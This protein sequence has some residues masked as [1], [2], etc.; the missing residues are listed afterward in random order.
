[1]RVRSGVIKLLI[2]FM[3]VALVVT[4]I[5]LTIWLLIYAAHRSTHVIGRCKQCDYDLRD[6]GDRR[7]CPE[8]G[9]P[10]YVNERGDVVS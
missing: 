6:L 2:A 8:C 10:F 4:P 3:F 1:M 9:H 7:A 5:V